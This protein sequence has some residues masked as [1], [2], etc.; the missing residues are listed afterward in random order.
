MAIPCSYQLSEKGGCLDTI[1]QLRGP[2]FFVGAGDGIWI[3]QGMTIAD[4]RADNREPKKCVLLPLVD[5]S[6]YSK[7][8]FASTLLKWSRVISKCNKLN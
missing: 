4:S 8:K 1:E 6:P 2:V 7:A 5:R 3:I